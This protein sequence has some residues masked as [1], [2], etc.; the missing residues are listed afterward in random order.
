MYG[1]GGTGL[2]CTNAVSVPTQPFVSETTTNKFTDS[3]GDIIEDESFDP[4][5]HK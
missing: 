5:D 1:D 3:N 2:T 4:F